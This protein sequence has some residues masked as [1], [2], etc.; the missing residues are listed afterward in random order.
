MTD[1]GRPAVTAYAARYG[2]SEE[3]YVRQL[4]EPLTPARAG[5]A[6]VELAGREPDAIGA[7]Y[8]LTADGLAPLP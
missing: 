2:L 3:E 4:G 1:L 8:L 5:K 6:L 7:A